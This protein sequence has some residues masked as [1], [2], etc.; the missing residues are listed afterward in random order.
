ME[1]AHFAA[2]LVL[3]AKVLSVKGLVLLLGEHLSL[4]IALKLFLTFMVLSIL[5]PIVVD[6]LA[7]LVWIHIYIWK[8]CETN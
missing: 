8:K 7:V 3:L 4:V 6:L 2:V 5:L 1:V